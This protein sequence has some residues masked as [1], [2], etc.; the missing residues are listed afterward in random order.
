[1]AAT[2]TRK[3]IDDAGARG[4]LSS[5]GCSFREQEVTETSLRHEPGTLARA[6]RRLADAGINVDAV[7]PTG[8]QGNDVSVGFVTD[9]PAK[10]REV[11]AAAAAMR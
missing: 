9:N 11:L 8:L 4:A 10:A 2:R 5:S 7:F 6:A 3:V 1:M